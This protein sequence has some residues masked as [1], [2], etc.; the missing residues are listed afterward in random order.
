MS[1]L[2][3]YDE[4]LTKNQ[5][6]Q[7]LLNYNTSFQE[8]VVLLV[9]QMKNI[10][11]I[12][13]KLYDLKAHTIIQ[14][15]EDHLENLNGQPVH[16]TENEVKINTIDIPILFKGEIFS[17]KLKYSE[18]SSLSIFIIKNKYLCIYPDSFGAKIFGDHCALNL[19]F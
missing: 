17:E 7:N 11:E 2:T 5:F 14:K 16:I 18:Q 4:D 10:P 1:S 9:P 6:F 8:I 15:T 3:Q 19:A 13:A 12:P